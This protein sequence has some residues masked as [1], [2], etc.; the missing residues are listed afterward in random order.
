MAFDR[1]LSDSTVHT[2]NFPCQLHAEGN[3]KP[4]FHAPRRLLRRGWYQTRRQHKRENKTQLPGPTVPGEGRCT[5]RVVDEEEAEEEEGKA[6][7]EDSD[8][9]SCPVSIN[10]PRV[11]KTVE[12]SSG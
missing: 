4:N 11:Y 10:I 2:Y 9:A 6:E 3:I 5:E 1:A 8:H 12:T 7:E